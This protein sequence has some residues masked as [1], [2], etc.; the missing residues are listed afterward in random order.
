MN[1]RDCCQPR[2][3]PCGR[4]RREFL[5]LKALGVAYAQ[6][7]GIRQPHAIELIANS[8]PAEPA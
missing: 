2:L 8:T 4:T 3:T 1:P 7:F 6:G 5:R